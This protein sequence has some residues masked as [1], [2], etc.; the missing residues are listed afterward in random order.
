VEHIQGVWKKAKIQGKVERK[1]WGAELGFPGFRVG[2]KN[3]QS[4][5]DAF[6]FLSSELNHHWPRLDDFEGPEYRR[7]LAKYKSEDGKTGVGYIYA[8]NNEGWS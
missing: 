6:V 8:I 3:D 2:T 5:I 1:G 7:I 4:N